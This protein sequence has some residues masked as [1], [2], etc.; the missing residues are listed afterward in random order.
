M[1][2]AEELVALKARV[3]PI[4][5]EYHEGRRCGLGCPVCELV[6]DCA[7]P[8]PVD[9]WELLDKI[10][11]RLRAANP[12]D[13]RRTLTEIDAALAAHEREGKP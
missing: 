4:L 13:W 2:D 5:T 6:R 8:A 3:Y 12:T 9:P 7:P 11:E 10:Q 1:T